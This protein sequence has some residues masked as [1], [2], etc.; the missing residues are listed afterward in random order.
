MGHQKKINVKF[1]L[2]Y[3]RTIEDGEYIFHCNKNH[4]VLGVHYTSDTDSEITKAHNFTGYPDIVP[5]STGYQSLIT[6]PD[7][8]HESLINPP[9]TYTITV[10]EILNHDGIRVA[11]AVLL[12]D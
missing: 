12:Y 3:L 5:V 2:E 1:K 7:Y 8:I 11:I 10:P 4:V 6:T 9:D